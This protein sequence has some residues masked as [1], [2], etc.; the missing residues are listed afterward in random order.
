MGRT[1]CDD[2]GE[3]TTTPISGSIYRGRLI[4][5][6]FESVCRECYGNRVL[7]A[8]DEFPQYALR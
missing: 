7:K 4:E 1:K 3:M 5:P 2:C 6:E 8:D